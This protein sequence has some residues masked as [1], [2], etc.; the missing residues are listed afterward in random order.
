M[1]RQALSSGLHSP[2]HNSLTPS[3]SAASSLRG[4]YVSRSSVFIQIKQNHHPAEGHS[5]H[6]AQVVR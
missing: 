3:A 6:A 4:P 1:G 5:T 2:L